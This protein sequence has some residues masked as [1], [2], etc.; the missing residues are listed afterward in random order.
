LM[1]TFDLLRDKYR[2]FAPELPGFGQS[3]K[4]R[5][6]FNVPELA[7]ILSAWLAAVDLSRASFVGNSLGCQVIVELAVRQPET[8]DHLVLVGPTVDTRDRTM[9]R[10]LWRG[11]RDLVHE[12][13]SLWLI[14][15]LDYLQTGTRRMF[16]T[17]RHALDDAME[18]KMPLVRAPTL[19]VRGSHDPIAPQ[20]WVEELAGLMPGSRLAIVQHGTHAT[21]YSSPMELTRIIDDFLSG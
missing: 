4:P 7:E 15:A 11:A 16:R 19:I 13:W 8:V 5:Q 18:R 2:V 14:L 9:P 12:P 3:D 6:I 17:F 1:P 21:N 20:R 10:Q